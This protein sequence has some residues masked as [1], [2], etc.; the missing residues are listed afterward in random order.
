VRDVRGAFGSAA[1]YPRYVSPGGVG[2]VLYAEKDP[3]TRNKMRGGG[4]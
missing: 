3:E 2:I 4:R 1:P